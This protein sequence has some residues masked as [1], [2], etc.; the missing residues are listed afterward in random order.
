M[1]NVDGSFSI[2]VLNFIILLHLIFIYC[3]PLSIAILQK[4]NIFL[5]AIINIL[6]G[7]TLIGWDIALF[8]ALK[9]KKW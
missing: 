3:I 1:V 4:Q 6:T 7:W 8:L 2:Q 5:I 9:N